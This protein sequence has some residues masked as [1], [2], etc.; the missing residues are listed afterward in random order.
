M[1]KRKSEDGEASYEEEGG[2]DT[3]QELI[4]AK[5]ARQEEEER[6]KAI[7]ARLNFLKQEKLKVDK[8]A[9]E[10]RRK[11][12][13]ILRAKARRAEELR[14]KQLLEE[15]K[16]KELEALRGTVYEKRQEHNDRINSSKVSLLSTSQLTAQNTKEMLK[17]LREQYAKQKEHEKVKTM[18][19]V[20]NV[21]MMKVR[22]DEKKKAAEKE[23][24]EIVKKCVTTELETELAKK[25]ELEAK[26]RLFEQKEKELLAYLE[27]ANKK[28]LSAK[29]EYRQA[30]EKDIW[31]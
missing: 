16:A 20:E 28:E 1:D 19:V 6:V 31:K 26:L 22:V 27:E 24:K 4:S 3:Y 18:E 25:N 14:E 17:E 10:V 12:Q 13:E 5:K 23:K 21:R 2:V 8:S 9:E 30:Q 29:E 15:E 11:A 7:E